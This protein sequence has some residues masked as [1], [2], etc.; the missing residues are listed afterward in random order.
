MN[1]ILFSDKSEENFENLNEFDDKS[2]TE[3]EENVEMRWKFW[4]RTEWGWR[5]CSWLSTRR[6]RREWNGATCICLRANGWESYVITIT[7]GRSKWK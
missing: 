5:K 2:N 6:W 3:V 4:Y 7:E 1:K